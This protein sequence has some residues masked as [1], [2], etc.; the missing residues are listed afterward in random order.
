MNVA[1]NGSYLALV[2][3]ARYTTKWRVTVGPRYF[4]AERGVGFVGTAESLRYATPAYHLQRRYGN[5]MSTQSP[6]LS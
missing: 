3:L 4:S 1:V 6:P 2:Q 5:S